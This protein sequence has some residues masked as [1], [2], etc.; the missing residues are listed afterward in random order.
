MHFEILKAIIAWAVK[1]IMTVRETREEHPAILF[2]N[3]TLNFGEALN[4][5]KEKNKKKC[6]K[7]CKSKKGRNIH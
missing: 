6:R 3:C 5:V 4:P 2:K 1:W 7:N